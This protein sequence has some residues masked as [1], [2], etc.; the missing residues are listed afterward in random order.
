MEQSSLSLRLAGLINGFEAQH[1]SPERWTAQEAAWYDKLLERLGIMNDIICPEC[2][3]EE[4]TC[5]CFTECECDT[6]PHEEDE[7]P[8]ALAG[9]EVD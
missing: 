7:N 1:G 6:S 2:P 8:E 9:E 3:C 5:P 4:G